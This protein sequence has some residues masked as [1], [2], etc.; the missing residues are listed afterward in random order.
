MARV[1]IKLNEQAPIPRYTPEGLTP[2]HAQIVDLTPGDNER[3]DFG[4]FL[5]TP[6]LF[7]ESPEEELLLCAY[8]IREAMALGDE[9]DR[10]DTLAQRIL[11]DL[12]HAKIDTEIR[13]QYFDSNKPN[14][15]F[16]WPHVYDNVMHLAKLAQTH[17]NAGALEAIAE[18]G[19][20]S[21]TNAG[22]KPKL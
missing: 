5:S 14:K 19:E 2:I 8:L 17:K 4:F 16:A 15:K 18:R 1:I 20:A 13:I 12:V 6:L 22:S 3:D 10:S 21:V 7:P 11:S 9:E